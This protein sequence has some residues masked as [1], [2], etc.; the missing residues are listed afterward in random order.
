MQ[1]I[2]GVHKASEPTYPAPRAVEKPPPL[3]HAARKRN[4]RL[5]PGI[6]DIRLSD[7][8]CVVVCHNYGQFLRE[9]LDSVLNQV[10]AFE[11]IFVMDDRFRR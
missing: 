2:I 8:T 4:P 3:G 1:K 10:I 5:Y 7:A 11:D 9:C 6:P